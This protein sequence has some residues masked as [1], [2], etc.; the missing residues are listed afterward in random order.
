[1]LLR[2]SIDEYID[3]AEAAKRLCVAKQAILARIWA[4]RLAATRHGNKYLVLRDDVD[5]LKAK[6]DARAWDA[7]PEGVSD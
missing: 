7:V 5:H 3:V 1:M 4:H 6:R 2:P